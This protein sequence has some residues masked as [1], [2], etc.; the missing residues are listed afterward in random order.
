MATATK[1]I[2]GN[3]CLTDLVESVQQYFDRVKSFGGDKLVE[4]ER[5]MIVELP[6]TVAERKEPHLAQSE[7]SRL[8]EWKLYKGKWWVLDL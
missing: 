1:N 3:Y 8:M 4:L 7:L 2:V 5:F 6:E